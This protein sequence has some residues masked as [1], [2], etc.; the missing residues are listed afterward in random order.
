MTTLLLP[1]P[2]RQRCCCVVLFLSFLFFSFL[3]FLF[4]FR[5]CFWFYFLLISS[6]LLRLYFVFFFFLLGVLFVTVESFNRCSHE[7]AEKG[8]NNG[9]IDWEW[10]D[11]QSCCCLQT[12]VEMNLDIKK[13][14]HVLLKNPNT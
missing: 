3:F 4:I 7:V 1:C 13:Q 9:E 14:V 10:A 2:I 5:V 11:H 6:L 8:N 12:N